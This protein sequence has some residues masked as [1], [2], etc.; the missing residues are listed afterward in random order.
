MEKK[1]SLVDDVVTDVVSM[2]GLDVAYADTSGVGL[3][4][5]DGGF[6]LTQTG[7]RI[8]AK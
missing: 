6:I 1:K 4:Y 5:Q 3:R 8:K 7:F 2:S